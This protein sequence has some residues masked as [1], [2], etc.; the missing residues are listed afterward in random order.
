MLR[1][2]LDTVV[3]VRALINPKGRSGRLL[4]QYA[5]RYRILVSRETLVELLEVIHRPELTRK[6]RSLGEVHMKR[7]LDLVSQAELVETSGARARSRDPKDDIFIETA[8]SGRAHCIVS[9]DKDLLSLEKVEGIPILNT[10]S[11]LEWIES[12]E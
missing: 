11:F 6:Y 9:E 5:D 7:V 8:I 10:M 2:V 1:V 3:F 12:Q 4:F